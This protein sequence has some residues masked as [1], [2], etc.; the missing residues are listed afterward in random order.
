M[1]FGGKGGASRRANKCHSFVDSWRGGYDGSGS[2]VTGG[3]ASGGWVTGGGADH[4]RCVGGVERM[5]NKGR[6]VR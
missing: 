4:S 3:D 1:V 2:G 6:E 5:G